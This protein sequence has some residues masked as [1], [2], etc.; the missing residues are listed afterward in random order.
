MKILRYVAFVVITLLGGIALICWFVRPG[1]TAYRAHLMPPLKEP[2]PGAIAATWFGVTGV[3]LDD[4]EHSLLIDPFFT[5][6]EGMLSFLGNAEIAP[7]E[8]RIADVLARAGVHHVDAVLVSHS[9]FDHAMDAGVVARLTGAKLV[10]SASTANIGRGSSLAD[11]QIH[12]I[13]PGETL[14]FGHF[15][16][17]FIESRHAGATGGRPTGDITAPLVPP[18][19][20][21]DYKQGG[22]Y[23][24]FIEHP[25]GNILHHGSA[26]FIPGA[27]KGLHADVVF[28]GIALREDLPTYLREVVDAVGARRVIPVHWDD[29]T[30]GLD[31][32]M[33]PFPIGIRLENFF[34]E[35]ARRDDLTV[36]T[37]EALQPAELFP[38]PRAKAD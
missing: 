37:M 33:I 12:V 21:L 3:L 13:E 27:L 11:S 34:D 8:K 38:R 19:H 2:H 23:S 35:I 32:P 16:V 18:A 6:P 7:D 17:R 31:Q 9:H 1:M 22:T 10:G 36:Q 15:A 30:R 5:R 24:I 20:Y 29:F 4:G 25:A 28:L 14:R 26:G